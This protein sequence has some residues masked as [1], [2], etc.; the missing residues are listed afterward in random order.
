MKP[1]NVGYIEVADGYVPTRPAPIITLWRTET[2]K[3]PAYHVEV[4]DQHGNPHE[5]I[6]KL[7]TERVAREISHVLTCRILLANAGE[8]ISTRSLAEGCEP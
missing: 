4:I 7:E 3:H 1:A 8:I 6:A 2:G 5:F